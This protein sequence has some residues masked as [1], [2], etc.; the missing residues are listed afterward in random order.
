MIKEL[1]SKSNVKILLIATYLIILFLFFVLIYF[2]EYKELFIINS[3]FDNQSYYDEIKK[4]NFFSIL[5]TFF[6][7][8]FFWSFFLGF[9]LFPILISAYL[10]DIYIALFLVVFSKTIGSVL[11]YSIIKKIYKQRVIKFLKDFNSKL[12][13]IIS[14]LKIYEL[15][16]LFILRFLPIPVQ[17]ADLGPILIDAKIKN[18]IIA[19]FFGSLVSH[20]LILQIL[21][22]WL[23]SYKVS[24][25]V[26]SFELLKNSEL[27]FSSLIF[28][29]FI[30]LI[31]IVKYILIKK[32]KQLK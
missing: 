31:N 20:F 8:T 6:F 25:K 4:Q 28:I 13:Y 30:C 1:F 18:F 19:K 15:S 29:I 11:L 24:G 14:N 10:F 9:G 16:T 26:V 22:S 32:S 7:F 5:I 12:F 3:F 17:L 21:Y 27:L 23:D 2:S